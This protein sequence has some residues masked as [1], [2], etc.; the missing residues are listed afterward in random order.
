MHD[1][2][3]IQHTCLFTK[4][5][6]ESRGYILFCKIKKNYLFM[7]LFYLL[8]STLGSDIDIIRKKMSNLLPPS[9]GHVHFGHE[10]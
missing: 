2:T 4:L 1:I 8:Y 7:I 5:K 9:Y 10:T 3:K 6:W